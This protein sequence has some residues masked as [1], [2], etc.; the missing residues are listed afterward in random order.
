MEERAI[1]AISSV[2]QL[3]NLQDKHRGTST[4]LPPHAQV[5][6]HARKLRCV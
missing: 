5:W 2:P 4:T 1:V 3:G 6:K